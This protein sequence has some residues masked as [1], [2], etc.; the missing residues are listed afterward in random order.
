[1][2]MEI[3]ASATTVAQ[4]QPWREMYR[5][6]MNCQIVHDS[7]HYREGWTQ[8]YALMLGD[9][10]VGYGSIAQA[11]PWKG[12]PTAFEFYVVPPYRSHVFKLFSAFLS[13]SGAVAMEVQTNDPIITVMFQSLVHPVLNEKIVFRDELT[14]TNSL[15]GAI[16]RQ[17]TSQDTAQIRENELDESAGSQ[18]WVVEVDGKVV[19][20]GGILYHYN[21]P[22]GD[23]FMSVSAAFRRRG[24]GSYLVQE[25]KR[26]CYE[27]GGIPAA[28][29]SPDNIA[30]RL[31]LQRAGLVPYCNKLSGPID[32][33]RRKKLWPDSQS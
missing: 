32:P 8:P 9:T 4:I 25:L 7:L 12:T 16:F 5:G 26:V 2:S 31:T 10:M 28:R 30:S 14:T 19:A 1:M 15:P 11:G 24:I 18:A 3:S 20:L 21:K 6:E 29:C 27:R 13:A 22:Y 33:E 23:I 17:V